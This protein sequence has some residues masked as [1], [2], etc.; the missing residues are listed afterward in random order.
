MRNYPAFAATSSFLDI[1]ALPLAVGPARKDI[2]VAVVERGDMVSIELKYRADRYSEAS[3]KALLDDYRRTL[4]AMT[5]NPYA[6]LRNLR[7]RATE[8]VVEADSAVAATVLEVIEDQLQSRCDATAVASAERDMSFC[9]LHAS[10][11]GVAGTLVEDEGITGARVAIL[12]SHDVELVEA[13]VGVAYSG[14]SYVPVAPHQPRTVLRSILQAADVSAVLVDSEHLALAREIAPARARIVS[15]ESARSR[16]GRVRRVCGATIGATLRSLHVW[17]D[18]QAKRRHAVGE[19]RA[20]AG[21]G[22]RDGDR[23][24]PSRP[25]LCHCSR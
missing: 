3:A 9:Q 14:N 19:S 11:V 2:D 20:G 17:I 5:K 23:S 24:E 6:Q 25:T 1:E 12:C 4:D 10:A 16:R 7:L 15:I 18:R 21:L 13:I 22:L 8:H